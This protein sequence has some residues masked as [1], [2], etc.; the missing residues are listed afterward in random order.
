MMM[1]TFFA[2]I[3]FWKHTTM[4]KFRI[5]YV[6]AIIKQ[7]PKLMPAKPLPMP[8]LLLLPPKPLLMPQPL[9]LQ[10]PMKMPKSPRIQ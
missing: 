2:Q 4:E 9:L 3:T 7:R 6:K 8:E 5:M 10:K 1:Q